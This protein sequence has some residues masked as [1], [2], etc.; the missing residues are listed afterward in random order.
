MIP[1]IEKKASPSMKESFSQNTSE[2][3]THLFVGNKTQFYNTVTEKLQSIFCKQTEKSPGCFCNECRKIKN[4]QHENIVWIEPEKEYI[5]KDLDV[6]FEKIKFA[7]EKNNSFFFI[8]DNAHTL[9][10]VCANKLLKTLEEPPEGYKFFLFTNN[11]LSIIPTIRSRCCIHHIS[12]QQTRPA[13]HPLLSFFVEES[14][15]EEK[16]PDPFLFDQELKKQKI[17][18]Q[19]TVELF[20]I[21]MADIKKKVSSLHQFL[22][23]KNSANIIE[24]IEDN[25]QYKKLSRNLELVKNHLRKPPQPGGAQMF[26][27]NFFIKYFS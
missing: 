1:D 7:L 26:W 18:E 25:E 19:E 13:A 17:S 21:L 14:I 3:P 12:I 24:N 15:F 4:R 16:R 11:E 23:K 10:S 2:I 20:Q 5:L 22:S 27:K 8:L 6:I 9:T